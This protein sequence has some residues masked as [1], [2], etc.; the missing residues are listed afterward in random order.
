M[1]QA[2]LNVIRY[3]Y[4]TIVGVFF[5]YGAVV[6]SKQMQKSLQFFQSNKQ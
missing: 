3:L 4:L 2:K 1:T 6:F 5:T